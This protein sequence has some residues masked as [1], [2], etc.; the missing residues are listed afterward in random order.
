MKKYKIFAFPIDIIFT[1]SV[2]DE[3]YDNERVLLN[4]KYCGHQTD[5]GTVEFLETNVT[6]SLMVFLDTG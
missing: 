1:E 4:C 5:C 6:Q 3:Y 2:C